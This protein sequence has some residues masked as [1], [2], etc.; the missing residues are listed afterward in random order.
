M[1]DCELITAHSCIRL[2]LRWHDCVCVCLCVCVCEC[3]LRVVGDWHS[4]A[5]LIGD[6]VGAVIRGAWAWAGGAAT[7]RVWNTHTHKS[8]TYETLQQPEI[9]LF[10]RQTA[11]MFVCLRVPHLPCRVSVSWRWWWGCLGAAAA[12]CSSARSPS[13]SASSAASGWAPRLKDRGRDEPNIVIDWLIDWLM[14]WK[15]QRYSTCCSFTSCL[16]SI[17]SY[18]VMEIQ[19]RVVAQPVSST[20]K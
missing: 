13:A 10:E 4:D 20:L 14:V 5:V 19:L 17:I 8:N 3:Y 2:N 15:L 12:G 6:V 18:T 16:S 1:H 9:E 7:R 11:W